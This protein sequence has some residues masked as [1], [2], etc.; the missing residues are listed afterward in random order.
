MCCNDVKPKRGDFF[1]FLFSLSFLEM[2]SKPWWRKMDHPYTTSVWIYLLTYLLFRGKPLYIVTETRNY[3]HVIFLYQPAFF[4]FLHLNS[5]K[6]LG[7]TLHRAFCHNS[8]VRAKCYVFIKHLLGGKALSRTVHMDRKVSLRSWGWSGVGKEGFLQQ[9]GAGSFF[10][11]APN[12]GEDARIAC[13]TMRARGGRN[14]DAF[15]PLSTEFLILST[16]IA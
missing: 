15:L 6:P 9:A 3:G 7:K 2:I 14:S 12:L 4:H 13:D 1:Q 5:L 16:L 10:T 11:R 8:S